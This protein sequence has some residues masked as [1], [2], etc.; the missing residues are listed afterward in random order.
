MDYDP[1]D[2]TMQLA[3]TRVCK[4]IN[5]PNSR[6]VIE[7][8]AGVPWLIIGE[9]HERF[10]IDRGQLKSSLKPMVK[11]DLVRWERG[12]RYRIGAGGLGVL[13][14]WIDFIG[15]MAAEAGH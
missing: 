1:D 6:R 10:D 2:P 11:L 14:S 4:I 3:L 12:G 9:L 8:L 13:R 5:D 7:I 15:R